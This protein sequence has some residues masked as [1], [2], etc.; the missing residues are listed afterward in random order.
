MSAALK[1]LARLGYVAIR[2][3]DDD[4]RRVQL[5]LTARG[6]RAMGDSSVLETG[7]VRALLRHLTP[8][9][10]R[11]AVEGLALLARAAGRLM[12]RRH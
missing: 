5:R 7:R 11:R 10:R 2:R 6:V 8:A 9:E 3:D 1:R 12:D 4:A